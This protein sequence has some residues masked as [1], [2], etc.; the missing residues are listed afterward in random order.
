LPVEDYPLL[1]QSAHR[2]RHMTSDQEFRRGLA[3]VLDG[4]EA[5]LKR[6]TLPGRA[7]K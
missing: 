4:L 7:V 6:P 1:S 2:A 5:S 3:I